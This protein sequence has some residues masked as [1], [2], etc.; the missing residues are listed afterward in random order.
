MGDWQTYM[1][2]FSEGNGPGRLATRQAFIGLAAAEL[3]AKDNLG[4][5]V[6][7]GGWFVVLPMAELIAATR[8]APRANKD[9]VQYCLDLEGDP[10]TD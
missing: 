9:S 5:L 10:L 4:Y 8:P 1:V 7:T 2:F 3:W 6:N